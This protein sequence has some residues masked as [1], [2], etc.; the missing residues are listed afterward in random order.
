V[1]SANREKIFDAFFTTKPEGLGMGLS[2]CRSIVE[3]HGGRLWVAPNPER[4]SI[5]SFVVPLLSEHT[6]AAHDDAG[7]W[8]TLTPEMPAAD[9]A[10]ER[11]HDS[12]G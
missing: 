2:I 4:G 8:D 1:E 3:A 11:D 5:F 6:G 9:V 10:L 7:L 12:Q